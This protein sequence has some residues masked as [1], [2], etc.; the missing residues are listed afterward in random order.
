MCLW[1]CL[2][3]LTASVANLYPFT[4]WLYQNSSL[5]T[6]GPESLQSSQAKMIRWSPAV[7]CRTGGVSACP[8]RWA[9]GALW[10]TYPTMPLPL[11]GI[12]GVARSRAIKNVERSETPE[13]LRLH[14]YVATS[15]LS[16]EVAIKCS[17][18]ME[19]HRVSKFQLLRL[20]SWRALVFISE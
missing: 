5:S 14:V 9:A 16:T 13:D 11:L 8:V 18:D 10:D 12:T 19:T 7:A 20:A 17:K 6:Y 2:C 1:C 3:C 15:L 4:L